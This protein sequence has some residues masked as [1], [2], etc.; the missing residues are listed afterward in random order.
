MYVPIAQVNDAITALNNRI[1]RR[2]VVG[3]T[4]S[5]QR[6]KHLLPVASVL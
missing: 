5:N 2:L 6:V 3:A 4:K 1:V